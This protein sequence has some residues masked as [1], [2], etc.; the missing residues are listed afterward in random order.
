MTCP[1]NDRICSELKTCCRSESIQAEFELAS[2][3][4]DSAKKVEMLQRF[5]EA[6]KQHFVCMK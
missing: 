4:G 3:V 6:F 5:N 2:K 1:C